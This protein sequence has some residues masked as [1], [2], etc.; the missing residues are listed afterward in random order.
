MDTALQTLIRYFLVKIKGKL[1][2]Q[3]VNEIDSFLE[4]FFTKSE[5]IAIVGWMYDTKDLKEVPLEDLKPYELLDM[6]GDTYFILE[7][8]I[9]KWDEHQNSREHLNPKKVWSVLEQLGLQTH[10]LGEKAIAFWDAYDYS[11]YRS[12]QIKAGRVKRVFGIYDIDV[13]QEDVE[14]VDTPP[15]RFFNSEHEAQRHMQY[16]INMKI[17]KRQ[18]THVLYC[19]VAT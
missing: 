17:I 10:Y 13:K 7:Y 14:K 5:L 18:D 3:K 12:L 4:D 19:Y 11:N 15:K 16:L 8:V 1:E 9:H 6:I 2:N